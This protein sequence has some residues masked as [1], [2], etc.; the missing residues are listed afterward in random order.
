MVEVIGIAATVET[1]R[2]EMVALDQSSAQMTSD[3][4]KIR[5]KLDEA[6]LAV[7]VVDV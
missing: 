3:V 6:R 2:K 7:Q 1:V 5:T 4:E